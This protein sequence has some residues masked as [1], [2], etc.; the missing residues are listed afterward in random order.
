MKRDLSQFR[1][2]WLI[3]F[4][5]SQSPG[6]LP[7]VVCMV[8]KELRS[9]RTLR[10][11]ADQLLLLSAPPFG[12]G[13]DTL[14]V[15]YFSS[16]E[17][18]CFQALGWPLPC[19][20]LD[21][22]VE[23]C[24]T[25]NGKTT[26]AGNSLLGAMTYLGLD[27]LS[28]V[29]K[30]DMRELAMRGGPYTDSEKKAL[31]DYCESDV[32]ALEK[33]LP[34]MLP[35]ID[36][37]RA[38]HRGR[39]M[40]AVA[41]M[42]IT[43]IPIDV[44]VMNILQSSWESIKSQLIQQVDAEYGVY[45]GARFVTKQ[46]EE[47][48]HRNRIHWPRLGSGKPKLDDDTFRAMS[49]T[50]SQIAPLH[51]LRQSLGTMRLFDL[52]VGSDGRNRCL[53]SPFRS[54]TGRNQPSNTKFPF[55]PSVWV[56]G[57]IRPEPDWSLAYV[58]WSQQEFGIAAALSGDSAMI[59]AYLSGDPY[60]EFAKQN[61]AAPQDATKQSH[62]VVRELFKQC[63][64]AVQY[65][66][67]ERSLSE[68]LG[69]PIV[70]GRQ[71]LLRHRTTYPK[72]WKW[73][74]AAVNYSLLGMPLQTVFGWKLHPTSNP[75]P[76]SLANFPVQANGAEMMR[77]A[78]ILATERGIRVCAP[79]HD[80]FLIEAP[81]SQIEAAVAEMQQVMRDASRIVLNGLELRS[82]VKYIHSPDRYMDERGIK[83]W[84]TVMGLLG[85]PIHLNR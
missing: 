1:E 18:G 76:R 28:T 25:T 29:E 82:D 44:P 68:R 3:D 45:D 43:G 16:A 14:I 24:N 75:N 80:A 9:G 36:S 77:L 33:L 70:V 10:L 11:W 84:N 69:K 50:H 73:S 6:N 67:E 32:N 83:M 55:G 37:P 35:H 7:T 19:C 13:P 71:L 15:A 56:R 41:C 78:A 2:I 20:V 39:Y 59:A 52:P 58:D 62:A 85:L 23:F 22:Y 12:L 27:G 40:K 34:C 53:L 17:M 26:I 65:G 61:G 46:F 81:A 49:K 74:E 30:D 51:E 72:F 54:R 66:M 31:L 63:A 38:L 60:L 8:A 4:E 79:V 57:L 64:L 5:F 47:Y 21:L 42:E 48:I